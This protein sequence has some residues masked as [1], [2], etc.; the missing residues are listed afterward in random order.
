L[1]NAHPHRKLQIVAKQLSFK[2]TSGWGGKRSGAGR[3]NLSGTP[4]HMKR[5]G[6]SL[7]FPLHV[8]LRLKEGLPSIRSKFLLKEFK[9]STKN[10]RAFGFYI[11]HFSIQSNH[12]HLFAE[13][14]SQKGIARGMRALAG[15]FAKIVRKSAAELR[16][17]GQK[18]GRKNANSGSVFKGR[19]HLHVLKT[20]RETRNALEYVLL[21]QSKHRNFTEFIDSY[22]SGDAFTQWRA[23]LKGKF[24]GLM[25]AQVETHA[26]LSRDDDPRATGL[27][28]VLS[29]PRSWLAR[30]GWRRAG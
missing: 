26:D 21:N 3:K 6:V 16:N 19:Y 29:K 12:I 1:T 22:S 17:V 23:L 20:P 8:T 9:K 27:D 7:K 4:N 18:S 2:K 10:A 15:R 28:D 25:R 11:I 13:A 5:P 30:E 24:S 14:E